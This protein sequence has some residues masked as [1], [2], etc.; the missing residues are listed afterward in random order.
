MY[1]Y[2][3][4]HT[5][6]ELGAV[7]LCGGLGASRAM[8]YAVVAGRGDD[9]VGNSHSIRGFRAYYIILVKFDKQITILY[10]AIR[11]SGI[12]VSSTLPPS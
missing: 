3:H 4:I 11:G 1:T 7:T 9:G 8:D 2:T 12:S 10:R 5:H 6:K